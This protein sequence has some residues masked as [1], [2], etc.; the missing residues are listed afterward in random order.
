MCINRDVSPPTCLCGCSLMCGI[1]TVAVLEG[2]GL[3]GAIASLEP[4][5]I[6]GSLL[7]CAP[8]IALFIWSESYTVRNINY[9]W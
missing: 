4:F 7:Q 8:L 3:L 5:S 6:M 1:I 2:L 9:I